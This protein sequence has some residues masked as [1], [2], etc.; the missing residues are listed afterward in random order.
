MCGSQTYWTPLSYAEQ[1]EYRDP[2]WQHDDHRSLTRIRDGASYVLAFDTL[3]QGATAVIIPAG[4]SV[5]VVNARTPRVTGPGH[6]FANADATHLGERYRV[7]IPHC[8]L[9]GERGERGAK[10]CVD[11]SDGPID[12]TLNSRTNGRKS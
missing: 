2:A 5:E 7:R 4:T 11:H 6:Y 8:A 9:K 1:R 3:G 12:A 10:C